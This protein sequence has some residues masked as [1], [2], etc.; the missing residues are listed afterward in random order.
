M[1]TIEARLVR[2]L[3]EGVHREVQA[4]NEAPWMI[5]GEAGWLMDGRFV[6]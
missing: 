6:A 1:Q 2:Y 4:K 3:R 5:V